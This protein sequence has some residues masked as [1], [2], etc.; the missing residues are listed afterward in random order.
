MTPKN[1]AGNPG[2]AEAAPSTS[3][4]QKTPNVCGGRACIRKT[5]I[6]VW[7]LVLAR[8]HGA[9]DQELLNHYVTP[10]TQ[11]DLD[12]A[13]DYYAAHREEIEADIRQN[14]EAI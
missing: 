6:P 12:A 8:R 3:W 11:A 4:I 7:I 14:E 10:L 9:T 2:T 5:R 13:W 1:H